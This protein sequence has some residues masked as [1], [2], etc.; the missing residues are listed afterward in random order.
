MA[1]TNDAFWKDNNTGEQEEGAE[2][3]KDKEKQ[4]SGVATGGKVSVWNRTDCL[5]YRLSNQSL[6]RIRK[7]SRVNPNFETH[8]STIKINPN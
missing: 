5:A 2:R 8:S 7:E 4:A 3:R 6:V 1:G